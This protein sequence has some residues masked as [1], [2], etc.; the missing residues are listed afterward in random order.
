VSAI[1]LETTRTLAA[2]IANAPL[3]MCRRAMLTA[4]ALKLR[5]ALLR[6]LP[7]LLDLI[8][9]TEPIFILKAD[10][11]AETQLRKHDEDSW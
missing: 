3:D 8:R 1:C 7:E 9:P 6:L 4:Q 5:A 10:R 2:T 11:P